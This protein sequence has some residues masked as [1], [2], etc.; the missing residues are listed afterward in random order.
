MPTR[1]ELGL[2]VEVYRDLAELG[3]TERGLLAQARAACQSSYS[4]YSGFEVGAAVLLADGSV[5][6]GS[7][8]ENAAYPSGLCAER[9][10]L[11]AAGC[12]KPG[13]PVRMIAVTARRAGSTAHLT[14]Y[15]C[16]A[17]RQVMAEYENLH[18]QPIRVIID[19]DTEIIVAES[20]KILLPLSFGPGQL[21]G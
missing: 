1:R 2:W 9:T 5:V 19:G 4:P 12:A 11:F 14:A 3:E 7:N 6:Q 16:G 20:I 17:C 15:P 18:G 21:A 13:I 10:A 8:Q